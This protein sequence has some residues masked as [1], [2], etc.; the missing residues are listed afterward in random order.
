[1]GDVCLGDGGGVGEVVNECLSVTL[2]VLN[3]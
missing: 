3:C 2:K 1:M